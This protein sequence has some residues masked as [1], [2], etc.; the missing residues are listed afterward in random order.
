MSRKDGMGIRAQRLH[1][2]EETLNQREFQY[3]IE[4][5]KLLLVYCYNIGATKEKAK[6]YLEILIGMGKAI[7]E[8]PLV[9]SYQ[10]YSNF[11]KE[12]SNIADKIKED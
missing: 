3:G 1:K 9:Y 4:E 7:K 2:M 5:D 11:E 12:R 8:G 6:E 10:F